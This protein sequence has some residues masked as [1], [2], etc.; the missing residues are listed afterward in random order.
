MQLKPGTYDVE[1]YLDGFQLSRVPM[2]LTRGVAP[3]PLEIRLQPST[4]PL[5]EARKTDRS[6]GAPAKPALKLDTAGAT[7]QTPRPTSP[8]PVAD[9]PRA[10]AGRRPNPPISPQPDAHL[11]PTERPIPTLPAP[12]VIPPS[13]TDLRPA[14]LTGNNTKP[15]I[16][17]PAVPPNLPPAPHPPE[18]HASLPP[19]QPALEANARGM[20]L[21]KVALYEEAVVSFSEAIRLRPDFANAYFN[22]GVAYYKLGQF[23]QAISDFDRA[24]DLNPQDQKAA[25][26]KQEALKRLASGIYFAGKDVTKPVSVSWT[27]PKYSKEAI[28]A[29]KTGSVQLTFVVDEYGRVKDCRV[30]RS[31]TPDLDQRAMTAA[32][33]ARFKPGLKGGKPVPVEVTVE[34]QFDLH[35]RASFAAPARG[36]GLQLYQ[37]LGQAGEGRRVSEKLKSRKVAASASQAQSNPGRFGIRILP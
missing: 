4:P 28:R 31:L 36:S 16:P 30:L 22:R 35:S 20:D 17:Q 25:Y 12:P 14:D 32:S 3:A 24:L 5:A 33:H 6:P 2:R 13:G 1:A 8:E 10:E 34:V 11:K 7:A 26:Q 15:I 18:Q 9:A 29:G 21:F 27:R 19:M 37:V 23:R